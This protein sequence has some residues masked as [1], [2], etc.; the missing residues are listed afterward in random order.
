M[1]KY[2]KAIAL[3]TKRVGAGE[4]D[5][6]HKAWI[7]PF[8][9]R[10]GCLFAFTGRDPRDRTCGCLTQVSKG[11]ADAATPELTRAIFTDGRI[12]MYPD[13]ITLADLPV[14]AEWQR[15][16]DRELGRS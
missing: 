12:P 2:D 1:D 6:I 4:V 10:A 16:L 3:L 5:A 13:E 7:A 15:R 14:F 8:E 11:M 9:N